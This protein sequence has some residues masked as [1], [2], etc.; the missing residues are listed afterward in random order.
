LDF[1]ELCESI[2]SSLKGTRHAPYASILKEIRCDLRAQSITVVFDRLPINIKYLFTLPDFSIFDVSELPLS[3]ENAQNG[4]GPYLLKSATQN[5][6]RLSRNPNY[7]A[8]LVSNQVEDVELVNYKPA[9]TKQFIQEM[10]PETH[11][12]AYFYGYA[13]DSGDLATLKNKG[14]VVDLYPTEWFVYILAK[15]GVDISLRNALRKAIDKFRTSE[16]SPNGLGVPAFSISPSDRDF[17]L[18]KAEYEG[19]VDQSSNDFDR[20]RTV[21]V[22]TS[23]SWAKIPFYRSI[24]DSLKA[25]F[26]NFVLKELQPS[27]SPKLFSAE[28]DVALALLGISPSDPLSHFSFLETTLNGFS[29]IVGKDEISQLALTADSVEFNR[30]IKAIEM[31]VRESGLVIPIAHFPGVVAHKAGLQRD[32]ANSFGWGIQTWSFRAN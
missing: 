19:V 28:T 4:T 17:S 6:V 8:E 11:D 27:E 15:K 10:S 1:N 31:K 9:E 25:T 12:A 2:K 24:I 30:K 20:N 18:S 5:L 13:V 14:Y 22:Y 16:V 7:P 26:P 3:A 23:A 32:D 29:G 21:T